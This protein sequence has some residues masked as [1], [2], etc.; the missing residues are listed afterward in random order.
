MY[1]RSGIP[2]ALRDFWLKVPVLISSLQEFL[3]FNYFPRTGN[4]PWSSIMSDW[5]HLLAQ[6]CPPGQ[7]GLV[8]DLLVS[9]LPSQTTTLIRSSQP[10]CPDLLMRTSL[11]DNSQPWPSTLSVWLWLSWNLVLPFRLV[12]VFCSRSFPPSGLSITIYLLR[13]CQP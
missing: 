5:V 6:L 1:L 3:A 8:P 13:S 12:L 2:V 9:R 7:P 11:Y 4:P 10:C